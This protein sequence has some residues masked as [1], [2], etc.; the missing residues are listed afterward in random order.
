M[1][2]PIDCVKQQ[3]ENDCWICCSVMIYNYLNPGRNK[4]TYKNRKIPEKIKGYMRNHGISPNEQASA[5]DCLAELCDLSVEIDGNRLPTFEDIQKEINKEGP[6]LCHVSTSKRK[7]Q[8]DPDG[9]CK[10]GHWIVIYGYE[11][12]PQRL[13]IRDPDTQVGDCIKIPRNGDYLYQDNMYFQS[14]TY[15]REENPG[16]YQ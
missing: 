8:D 6:L 4:M 3:Y 1:E 12:N 15:I 7:N 13:L 14:T 9:E 10:G 2:L 5:A 16:Q 11:E